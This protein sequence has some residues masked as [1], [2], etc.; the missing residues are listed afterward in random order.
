M[1]S[2]ARSHAHLHLAPERCVLCRLCQINCPEQALQVTPEAHTWSFREE[3]CT[4]C[5]RCL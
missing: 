3:R 4:R 1:A 2:Q 5:G